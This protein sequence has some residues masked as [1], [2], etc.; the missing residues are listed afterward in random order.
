MT[1][2]KQLFCTLLDVVI[3]CKDLLD[4][5]HD[6]IGFDITSKL[7]Q[8]VGDIMSLALENAAD[9][10][11]YEVL[12]GYTDLDLWYEAILMGDRYTVE[13]NGE[14]IDLTKPEDLYDFMERKENENLQ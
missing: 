6:E 9:I 10:W 13:L 5:L 7:S 12:P 8:E 4:Y 11:G 3:K 14:V 1:K 2:D